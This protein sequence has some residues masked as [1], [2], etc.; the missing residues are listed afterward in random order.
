MFE[1]RANKMRPKKWDV[2][3]Q[4]DD[5]II[6][7][8]D[9]SFDI[10]ESASVGWKATASELGTQ[11]EDAGVA[12]LFDDRGTNTGAST[13]HLNVEEGDSVRLVDELLLV[14][15]RATLVEKRFVKLS[16]ESMFCSAK[17]KT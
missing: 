5:L 10:T 13:F 16:T 8:N 1:D 4:F 2:S 11:A 17:K 9:I 7:V 3:N 12:E 14:S 15:L 6:I